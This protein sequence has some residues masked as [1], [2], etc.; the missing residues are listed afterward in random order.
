MA[1][2]KNNDII[3]SMLTVKVQ[4]EKKHDYNANVIL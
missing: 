3:L 4:E 1:L 2:N